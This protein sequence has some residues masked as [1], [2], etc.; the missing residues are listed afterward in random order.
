[1][2][3]RRRSIVAI[4]AT[5]TGAVLIAT[6]ATAVPVTATGTTMSLRHSPQGKVLAGKARQYAYVHVSG[7][8][9]VGCTTV[10]LTIWPRV[11]T[12]G[13]PRAGAGVT[14][15]KL[16]Q[17]TS[18]QV[19]YY[20]HPLFYYSPDPTHPSGDGATSFGGDWLLIKSNGKLR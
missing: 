12:K 14:Q 4:L 8:K 2:I 11:V 15:R 10:C 18:H 7:S 3:D 19:T 13:K 20:G 9:D 17:T 6:T 16:R 5:A 1:V